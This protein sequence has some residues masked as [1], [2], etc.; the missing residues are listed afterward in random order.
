VAILEEG[1]AGMAVAEVCRKHGISAPTYY[2]WKSN[3]A[4]ATVSGCGPRTPLDEAVDATLQGLGGG[5]KPDRRDV[6]KHIRRGLHT[7]K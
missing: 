5:L 6:H 1:E 7:H 2:A 3:Y 4:G